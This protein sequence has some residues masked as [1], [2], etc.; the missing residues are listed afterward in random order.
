M[1]RDIVTM[2]I[3]SLAVAC[4]IALPSLAA[5][6]P[7]TAGINLGLTQSKEDGANG[8]DASDTFGLYGRLGFTK[9][10][11]GQLEVMKIG[12]EDGS[13]VT[14][15]SGTMLLVVD[16]TNSGRL[17]PTISA[18]VGIDSASYEYGGTTDA[19]HIEGGFG[20]EY[21]AEGGLTIGVDLRM[22][23]RS[24]DEEDKLVPLA[25][26]A[27]YAPSGLREGEYRS[28]RLSLGVRF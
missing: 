8:Q 3:R 21:R 17:V 20:L 4:V 13:G 14:I 7:V 26:V 12:T 9:R 18:G 19:K 28:G 10:L 15:R 1:L 11:S 25:G 24:I 2:L 23:G 27:Y 5:A 22:G 16:L 6:N